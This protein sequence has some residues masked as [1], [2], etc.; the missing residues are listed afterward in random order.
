MERLSCAQDHRG[1]NGGS[2]SRAA[3]S[4]SISAGVGL[5][6]L[7]LGASWFFQRRRRRRAASA[8]SAAAD[9]DGRDANSTDNAAFSAGTWTSF[10]FCRAMLFVSAAYAV[11]RSLGV[12]HI[13]VLCQNG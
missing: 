10:F 4:L 2:I 7:A 12:R 5:T 8:A 3:V 6:L 9:N 1:S 13:R 11:V